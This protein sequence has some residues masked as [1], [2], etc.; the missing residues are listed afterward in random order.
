MSAFSL[1]SVR[2]PLILVPWGSLLYLS[3]RSSLLVLAVV[4]WLLLLEVLLS[5]SFRPPADHLQ[6]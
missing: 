2:Q 5:D 6:G 1:G 4:P 3:G